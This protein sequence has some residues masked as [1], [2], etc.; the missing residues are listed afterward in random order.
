[1]TEKQLEKYIKGKYIGMI[2]GNYDVYCSLRTDEINNFV[3]NA[4][5]YADLEIIKIRNNEILFDTN[6]Q[7]IN[8]ILPELT[9]TA[10]TSLEGQTL[11]NQLASKI[12][13][14]IINDDKGNEPIKKV[15]KFMLEAFGVEI[16]QRN[17]EIIK[18]MD[19]DNMSFYSQ[20][21]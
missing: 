11:I 14:M 7:F 9:E 17:D 20:L 1:M 15:K 2:K 10:R 8:R 19:K 21:M 4:G 12:N 16:V 6:G 5:R 3:Q 13:E 18:E